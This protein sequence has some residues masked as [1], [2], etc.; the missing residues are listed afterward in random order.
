M[1]RSG[2]PEGASDL[3]GR[4]VLVTGATG[5]LGR[6]LIPAIVAAG[7][8]PILMVRPGAPVP[9]KHDVVHADLEDGTA[10]RR[11]LQRSAPDVVFHLAA[12]TDP[13]RRRD[14]SRRM[15]AA[16]FLATVALAEAAA[17]CGAHRFVFTG[18][19][20]EYGHQTPPFSE[21]LPPDPLSPYSASKA[22]ATIWLRMMQQ[23]HGLPA[24]IL[25][26]FLVYGPG[27]QPPRLVPS[28]CAAALEG[29]DFPMT[30]GRQR[31]ELTYVADVVEGLIRAAV[32]RDAVGEIIN[33]GAGEEHTVL[34][35]V[36]TIYRLAGGRGSPRPGELEDRPNDMQ[37]FCADTTR[38][39]RVLDWT[40]RTPLTQGLEATLDWIRIHGDKPVPI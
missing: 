12:A 16:N 9:A 1:A 2:S 23:T 11:E 36:E 25:R 40:A 32:A 10:L 4:R 27:Q 26:P 19:C 22:A 18:T 39:K 5:F 6:H 14:L 28:A 35:I 17:D 30:S 38:A 31:R 29:R 21:T 20:E 33:L 8:Q 13:S 15:L 3:E 7:G 24:V 37:R 34:S